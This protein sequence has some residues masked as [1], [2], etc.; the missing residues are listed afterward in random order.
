MSTISS[1]IGHQQIFND[2][3]HDEDKPCKLSSNSIIFVNHIINRFIDEHFQSPIFSIDYI[4]DYFLDIYK[5]NEVVLRMCRHGDKWIKDNI[6]IRLEEIIIEHRKLQ[7]IE[8]EQKIWISGA[9]EYLIAEIYELSIKTT[10]KHHRV[11]VKDTHIKITIVNDE[12]LNQMLCLYI[13]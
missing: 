5:N 9:L 1:K 7:N 2:V 8:N 11:I 3:N 4:K 6:D 10:K 12:D 13:K